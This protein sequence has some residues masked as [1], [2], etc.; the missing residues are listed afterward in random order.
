MNLK[1]SK[2]TR[3]TLGISRG[4]MAFLDLLTAFNSF[5]IKSIYFIYGLIRDTLYSILT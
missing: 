5:S 1:P 3:K 4:N 2:N